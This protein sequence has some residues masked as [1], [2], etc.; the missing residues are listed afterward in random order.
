MG[1]T[2]SLAIFDTP[3]PFFSSNPVGI[4]L[5]RH[6]PRES[7]LPQASVTPPDPLVQKLREGDEET[8]GVLIAKYYSP[9]MRV[10]RQYVPTQAIAEEVVQETWLAF[11]ESLQRFEGR[12]SIKTWLF[13]ILTNRA[14]TRG[15]QE[16]RY[17]PLPEETQTKEGSQKSEYSSETLNPDQQPHKTGRVLSQSCE[18]TDPE[19]NFLTK[20]MVTHIESAIQTLPPRHQQIIY[21]RDVEG[22]TPEEVC[23]LL[24]ISE[25]NQRVL[26][27]R[28]RVGVRDKLTPFFESSEK[29]SNH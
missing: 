20:E 15:V 17:V 27:H 19:K 12:C 6:E 14:K 9:M 28:A 23:E 13:R 3:K 29:T 2:Q 21:L 24:H 5:L 16:H 10:A 26:L 25:G 7:T 11:L 8:Y 18:P 1:Y 22:W 4:S